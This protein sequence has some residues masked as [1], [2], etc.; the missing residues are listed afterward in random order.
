VVAIDV[1]DPTKPSITS[2][3]TVAAE[4]LSPDVLNGKRL[5]FRSRAPVHSESNYVACASCHADGGAQDGQ[6]WDLTQGGEGLRNTIDLRGRA[7]MGDGFV[8][9][10]ANFD[11]IQD[12]EN[13]I[14]KL[15]GG[16]GLAADGMPPNP[17]LGAP[18]AGRSQDLDDLAAYVTSLAYTPRSPL[19]A[20]DGTMSEAALRGEALFLDP[21]RRC[22]ECHALPRYTI[23]SLDKL[24]LFDTGTLGPGTGM[25][26][27]GPLTGID[28]PTLIGLWD[29][30][31][32]FH[33]GSAPTLRDVF[34]GRDGVLEAQLTADLDDAQLGDLMAYLMSLDA[35]EP[36]PPPPMQVEPPAGCG[37]HTSDPRSTFAMLAVV[38]VVLSRHRR[39]KGETS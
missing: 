6:V 13:P 22:V 31:P 26:L 12:F 10:S 3:V 25:R 38:L 4:P 27:G 36:A 19:R 29:G 30:A 39:T 11:E 8:H 9:W 23:S 14:V 15:F 35:V 16:T 20:D 21:A 37:C 7:G 34:R 24:Q 2:R 18:N 32:Y 5:F 1:R 28:V 17:P 33:D